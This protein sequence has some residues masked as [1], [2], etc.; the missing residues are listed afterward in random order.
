MAGLGFCDSC[1]GSALWTLHN[2]EVWEHCLGECS[3]AFQLDMFAFSEPAALP[4][5]EDLVR[6][7]KSGSVS[8]LV[9]VEADDTSSDV[10]FPNRGRPLPF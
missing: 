1:G 4:A 3:E 6:L 2:D 5:D 7:D 8:G 10:A 9:E